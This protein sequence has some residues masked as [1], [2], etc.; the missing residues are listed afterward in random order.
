MLPQITFDE[1]RRR[2]ARQLGYGRDPD[3]LANDARET[4]ILDIIRSAERR[5]YFHAQPAPNQPPHT[6][7][8]LTPTATLALIAAQTT[9]QLPADYTDMMSTG[10]IFSG[11]E[12][13][14]IARTSIESIQSMQAQASR[15]GTPSYFAIR[16]RATTDPGR[17]TTYEVVFYPTPTVAATLSY[18]YRIAPQGLSAENVYPMGGAQHSETFLE[19]C[20]AEADKMF[21]DAE[22]VHEKKYLE[23][24]LGS[25]Q[26]DQQSAAK[27]SQPWPLEHPATTLGVTKL[28]LRRLIGDAMGYGAHPSTWDHPKSERVKLALETALRMFYNPPAARG[29]QFAHEWSFLMPVGWVDT[30]STL[31]RYDLPDDFAMLAGSVVFEPGDS[32]MYPALTELSERELARRLQLNSASSRPQIFA[33]RLKQLDEGTGTKL[34]MLLWPV[35]DDNYRLNFKY[36]VNPAMLSDDA[37]LPLGG[38]QHMQTI[39]ECCLAAAEIAM[40]QPGLHVQLAESLMATSITRDQSASAPAS[41]G[42]PREMGEGYEI[43]WHELDENI[44]TYNGVEY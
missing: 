2:I 7:T 16:P 42:F 35:P 1:L 4:D 31:Y 27:E 17:E 28:Y 44:T 24:L 8:F 15:T 12:Q 5:F 43:N 32:A 18:Q 22:S 25:I 14:P 9:Y 11:L 23:L 20:M 36:R 19:C 21:T 6:W 26:T 39:I 37:A 13:A 41:L 34:E 10:F 29:R 30:V 33:I 38:E 3:K 40:N